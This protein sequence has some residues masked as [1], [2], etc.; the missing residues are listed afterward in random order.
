MFVFNSI[1]V[2][3]FGIKIVKSVKLNIANILIR[4]EANET[5]SRFVFS[6]QRCEMC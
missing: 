1:C 2:L 3:F 4:G 5:T 6:E